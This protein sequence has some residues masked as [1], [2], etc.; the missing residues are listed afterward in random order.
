VDG[1]NVYLGSDAFA[2]ASNDMM[3][4][5]GVVGASLAFGGSA[6]QKIRR[7]WEFTHAVYSWRIFDL[8]RSRSVARVICCGELGLAVLLAVSLRIPSLR[9]PALGLSFATLVGFVCFQVYLLLLRPGSSCGCT[10]RLESVGRG[11]LTRAAV[12]AAFVAAVLLWR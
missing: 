8:R 12:P 7:R 1:L 4:L 10:G 5:F 9:V 11:S 6:V 2:R 3:V